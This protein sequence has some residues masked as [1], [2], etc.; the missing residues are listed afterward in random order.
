MHRRM[1]LV[2]LLSLSAGS[3]R[4]ASTWLLVT[5]GEVRRD[6]SAPQV[7]E[8]FEAITPDAPTIEILQPDE[9]KPIPTPVTIKIAFQANAG[10]TIDVSTFRA[11]YGFLNIDIT[12][13]LLG[14]AR[15]DVSGLTADNASIPS[16]EHKITLSIA[17]TAKRVGF[18]IFHFKVE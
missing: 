11:T 14:H 1:M 12:S 15:I 2:T 9:K 6:R 17:D 18:R 5:P 4:S 10:S 16:G 13:R 7:P 8:L 3:A